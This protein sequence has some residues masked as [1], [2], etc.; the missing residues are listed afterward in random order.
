MA[1]SCH[2]WLA[3][4]LAIAQ[5]TRSIVTP[6]PSVSRSKRHTTFNQWRRCPASPAVPVVT[7][8]RLALKVWPVAGGQSFRA[9]GKQPM[10]GPVRRDVTGRRGV[11]DTRCRFTAPRWSATR[12][13]APACRLPI[14]QSTGPGSG[15]SAGYRGAAAT[16]GALGAHVVDGGGNNGSVRADG[17]RRGRRAAAAS[18]GQPL[19]SLRIVS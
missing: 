11:R 19:D 17:G 12:P 3:A 10:T 5:S 18:A 7:G 6:Q 1:A 13:P 16:A 8:I 2:G 15:P 4:I 9:D 14:A